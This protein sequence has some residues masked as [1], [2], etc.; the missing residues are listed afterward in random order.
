MPTAFICAVP[1]MRAVYVSNAVTEHNTRT[2]A[3]RKARIGIILLFKLTPNRK[4]KKKPDLSYFGEKNHEKRTK[5]IELGR[6]H[7]DKQ[8]K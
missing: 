7:C 3:T 2:R 4:V 5:K 8:T 6:F 1:P